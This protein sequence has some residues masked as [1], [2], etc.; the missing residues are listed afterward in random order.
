MAP[1]RASG[2]A[3]PAADL[4]QER[5]R[6]GGARVPS[7][8]GGH[9]D[10]P[11]GALLHGLARVAVVDHVVQHDAAPAVHGV[12]DIG[13]GAQARDDDRHLVLRAQRH[14]A[15]EAVVAL[16]HDLVDGERRTRRLGMH[17]VVRGQR[18]GDLGEPVV[19]QLGRTC[20]ER[21][22]RTHDAGPA[23]RDHQRG[24]ADDEQRRRDHR[25][26]QAREGT[27]RVGHDVCASFTMPR[28]ITICWIWLVPS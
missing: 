6:A 20:V 13:T 17:P 14:V 28:A 10:E 2:P 16:V 4:V 18:L 25:Q 22:H 8:P 26:A 23:L 7:R 15:L 27:E 1:D 21:R 9:R 12:V 11:V 5:E 19:Q 24:R 3:V